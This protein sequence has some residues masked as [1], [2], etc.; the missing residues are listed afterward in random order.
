MRATHRLTSILRGSTLLKD[1]LGNVMPIAAAGMVVAVALVGSGVDMSRA[2]MVKSRLQAACDAGVLAGRRAVI[3]DGFDEPANDQA[4]AYFAANFSDGQQSTRNTVF[5]ATSE[6][7]GKTINGRATTRLDTAVMRVFAFNEF[8]LQ[9]NCTSTM[10]V[11]NSDI[12]MVLDVTGSMGESVDLDKDDGSSKTITKINALKNS[13]KSFYDTVEKATDGSNARVRYGFVPYSSSVNV[14]KLIYAEDPDYLVDRA[15]IQTRI[16]KYSGAP[17]D[18]PWSPAEVSSNTSVATSVDGTLIRYSSTPYTGSSASTNCSNARNTLNA[19]AAWSPAGNGDPVGA[20]STVVS[21]YGSNKVT[22]TLLSSLKATQPSY[23]CTKTTERQNNKN[24]TVYYMDYKTNIRVTN[25]YELKTQYLLV[26]ETPPGAF[27]HYVYFNTFRDFSGYKTG[28]PVTIVNGYYGE[29]KTYSW[30][31]CIQERQT[32]NS[33]TFTFSPADG[34]QPEGAYDLD[35]DLIPSDNDATKWVPMWPDISFL[36]GNTSTSTD[37]YGNLVMENGEPKTSIQVVNTLEYTDGKKSSSTCVSEAQLLSPMQKETSDKK[38]FYDYANKL[39][40]D[41]STYH[42]IGM[43]WGGRLLSPDGIF[44]DNVREEPNNG[45]S[46]SRHLIFMTDGEMA[47]VN[48]IQSSY[49]IEYYDKRITTNGSSSLSA[50]HT[51][52][53]KAVCQAVKAKGIRVWVIAFGEGTSLTTDLTACASDN[54][55]FEA[56]DAGSLNAAFQEIAKQVGELRVMQ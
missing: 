47:P 45:G 2:Y 19:N 27:H 43:I 56:K 37:K 25:E 22:S 9:V 36:R 46:V 24:V 18:G 44:R 40:A 7:D 35:I 20:S 14:G 21:K 1:N 53:F 39:K 30:A 29:N 48:T 8:D 13:M 15:M 51:A 31:G 26:P 4:K 33:A 55:A 16:P 38:G 34:I 50:R 6:D 5:S 42:D 52:R 41:G 28:S 23:V 32:I 17:D 54:S 11:G 49:G 12:V 10:G 3:S